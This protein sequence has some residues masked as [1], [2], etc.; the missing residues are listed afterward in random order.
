L[1]QCRPSQSPVPNTGNGR[2]PRI[3]SAKRLA[4]PALYQVAVSRD[5]HRCPMPLPTNTYRRGA[6]YW[7]RRTVRLAD[8]TSPTIGLGLS[9]LTR[10]LRIARGRAAAMTARSEASRTGLY[11]RIAQDGLS[12]DQ[13]YRLFMGEMT[14]Y[15]N[16]SSI[17][18]RAGRTTRICATSR[19]PSGIFR[20]SNRCGARLPAPAS[21]KRHRTNTPRRTSSN[22][23]RRSKAGFVGPHQHRRLQREFP[24]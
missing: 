8:S 1:I 23:T 11:S 7:W 19:T 22:S 14:E 2:K 4:G 6:V 18:L 12:S 5:G 24:G 3:Q 21:S 9:L 16:A 13:Q 10:E 20:C 17:R 15:R